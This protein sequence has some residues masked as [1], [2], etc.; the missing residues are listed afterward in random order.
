MK[1]KAHG[2]QK[3]K[4]ISKDTSRLRAPRNARA[5][6]GAPAQAIGQR[7]RKKV[8]MNCE[9]VISPSDPLFTLSSS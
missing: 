1:R 8:S 6:K 3:P 9:P 4:R 2:A 5:Y 7:F